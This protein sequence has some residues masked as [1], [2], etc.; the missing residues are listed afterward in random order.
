MN[1][2]GISALPLSPRRSSCPKTRRSRGIVLDE[3]AQ[4]QPKDKKRAQSSAQT[5]NKDDEL[6]PL[7]EKS[8]F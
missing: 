4:E 5:E 7:R 2:S 3:K 6:Q 1:A 8:G